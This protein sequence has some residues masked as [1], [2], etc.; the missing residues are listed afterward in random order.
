MLEACQF[1]VAFHFDEDLS[2]L[3]NR[4]ELFMPEL[5]GV[6]SL[7][8]LDCPSSGYFACLKKGRKAAYNNFDDLILHFTSQ[9]A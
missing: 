5:L 7:N 2:V 3:A 9:N 6:P 1:H 8:P 4:E